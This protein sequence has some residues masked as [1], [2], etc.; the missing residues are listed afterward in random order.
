MF[1]IEFLHIINYLNENF[2]E[3]VPVSQTLDFI[4]EAFIST[5]I[6]TKFYFLVDLDWQIIK[7]TSYILH[8][9]LEDK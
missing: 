7:I 6:C 4:D 9:T 8:G 1:G 5:V 3:F 2:P